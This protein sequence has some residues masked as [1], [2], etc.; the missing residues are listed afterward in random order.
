MS[1]TEFNILLCVVHAGVMVTL[2][3]RLY[4]EIVRRGHTEPEQVHEVL[5]EIVID[6]WARVP[7]L[8]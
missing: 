1:H 3:M 6:R 2:R 4:C 5:N 8:R 7:C